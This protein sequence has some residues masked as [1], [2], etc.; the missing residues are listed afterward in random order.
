ME[1]GKKPRPEFLG[2]DEL[3]TRTVIDPQTA[4]CKLGNEPS[5]RRLWLVTADLAGPNA[6]SLAPTSS[7]VD[8][9]ITC[10]LRSAKVRAPILACPL[11]RRQVTWSCADLRIEKQLSQ[12]SHA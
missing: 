4:C 11:A 2:I 12:I 8:R 1:R 3:R 10:F 5:Q 6:T 7:P 9:R